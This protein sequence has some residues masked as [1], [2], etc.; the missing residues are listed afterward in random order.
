MIWSSPLRVL[1]LAGL[2]L[3]VASGCGGNPSV[4]NVDPG[5]TGGTDTGGT[6]AGGSETTAGKGPVII[7][8]GG[9]D[10]NGEGGSG[11]MPSQYV[12]GNGMLEP[13]EFCDDGN[14][15]D[16][17]GCS[18]DCQVL[19]PDFD[20]S[21]VGEP[22]TQV[23]ICGDGVLEGDEAC[24]DGNT[25][26]ADG[27]SAD[28]AMVED[29]FECVRPGK[30]CVK[31]S[32]CGNT[33]RERGE[34]CD[35]GNVMTA[36]GCDDKCQI[37]AGFYCPLAGGMCD[38][39]E[40]GNSIR[41]PDEECEDHNT[42][43]GDGCSHL[44]KVEAGWHCNSMGCKPECGDGLLR[45]TEECDDNNATGGDGCSSA[46][47]EEPFY[48]CTKA[49]PSVCTSK[50]SCGNGK[51]DPGEICDPPGTA[52]CKAGCKSF[53]PDT[54]MSSTCGNSIIEGNE[55]CD[56][57]AVGN[58]CTAACKVEAGW[59]CPQAGFCFKNPFC[60]DNIVQT[61]EKCDPPNVGNG[62][63]ANCQVE[64]GWTCVGLGP[65]TCVK[66]VC[67][68]KLVDPGE[69]CDDGSAGGAHD[70]CFGCTIE[71]GWSCPTPGAAC[72][73]KCGD[74]NKLGLE[75]CDDGNKVSGDGCNAGCKI[76]VGYKCPTPGAKCVASVCGDKSVDAGEGCDDGG[77]CVGGTKA[78]TACTADATCTGGGKCLPVA[79]DGCGATC[80]P[81]PTVTVGP[82]P[83]VNVFCGDGLKTGTEVCDDG[84]TTDGD[85]CQADCKSVTT[86]FNCTDKV[87]L[88]PSLQMQVRYRDFKQ[89]G[90]TGGHP[91]FEHDGAPSE[92]NNMA[93]PLCKNGDT[94]CTAAVGATCA[95]GTCGWLDAQ[96]KPAFHLPND[97]AEVTTSDTFSLWYRD[98]NPTN[99]AGDHGTIGISP[100]TSQL[101][102]NQVGGTTSDVYEYDNS[103]FFPLTGLAFGNDGNAQNFHFTTE[104]R[105]YF[106]YKGGEKLIFRGDDDVWVFING[107][108][109]VDLG[110]VHCAELGQVILGD[111]DSSCSLNKAD[112]T[113]N[114]PGGNFDINACGTTGN[115]PACALS[116]AEMTDNTDGRF[117]LT[118]GGVYEIVLFQAERHTSQSNFRLT[119]QGFLAPRSSCDTICGD[120]IVAGDEYCDDGANNSDTVSGACNTTCT[121]R[122]YCG[123]GTKQLPGEACDNGTNTDLYKTPQS[124]ASVC[125]PGCKVPASCGDGSLQASFEEC[126]KGGQNNDAA[127]GPNECT[128]MCKLGG[129][130]GDGVTQAAEGET[131]DKKD[132]NGKEYGANSCGYDC[133]PGPRC[134]DHIRNGAEECDDGAD[135]GTLTSHCDTNC[136]IKPYC[137]DGVKQAS[138]QCDYG[139]FASPVDMPTYGGCTT[140][141]LLGPHCGDGGPG[142]T[143][144]PEEECDYGA[145]KND[146]SYKGCNAN[147]TLGPRCG[148]GIKNGTESCD[149]GFNA[150]EYNDPNT[151]ETECGVGCTPVPYCGDGALQAGFELCDDPN[152]NDDNKYNGCTTKCVYGPF[153]GDGHIDMPDEM[154]D[155]G[156]DNVGYAATKGGCGYDCQPAP[157]CGDGTR[158]GP[159]QC[160]LGEGKNTGDYGTCNAD[161]T[162]APRCGDGV[163]NGNEQCDDGPTGS[164]KCSVTCK[165]RD[166]PA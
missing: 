47:K 150:D 154:C 57:P 34:E 166:V 87:T 131:C 46:C 61:G 119:L 28:C 56:P 73:A 99:I 42:N 75:Q 89:R 6:S 126:D 157:Y 60:G 93:G 106:Q 35:D 158:N 111:E 22:C 155:D 44:C 15:K 95:A 43:D 76:E 144:D 135:N 36:D 86:G 138:E 101:T 78:G 128:T 133:Q 21:Q 45:G 51:V 80:Q 7:T 9:A 151:P 14:T 159:E 137:G 53:D 116:A 127:Y 115:P 110:G 129:Y 162:F 142:N 114:A 49:S 102:L 37:E 104:L 50:I 120:G 84:N 130:C 141:C 20:C 112:Y 11:D 55:T 108:L 125:A 54:T 83:T 25:K 90:S 139:Q 103:S 5:D 136:T 66:P 62:C 1:G 107:R 153:C 67:G 3:V 146:G 149:N 145:V 143:P 63:A 100:L 24:D 140:M 81:E 121:A 113:D 134:G 147:C 98:T 29:G 68:N 132:L 92:A 71:T 64:A 69:Q 13:G 94:Q 27:C 118:K 12:C 77:T 165:R 30:E 117:G 32:V 4:S 160:D 109:A 163:K 97:T 70:G 16:D 39:Q 148:D 85:G 48:S 26:D 41:T 38:K 23:V 152:G 58:G 2:W 40:C 156:T 72:I 79:G 161:C 17:D 18:A 74:G 19:D 65:S 91:D 82:A 122:A 31:V 52:G 10:D 33:V 8:T 96:G 105:Y 124:P 164:L 59:T 123:D 88:P